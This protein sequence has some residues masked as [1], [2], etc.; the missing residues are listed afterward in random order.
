[1]TW[2]RIGHWIV[3]HAERVTTFGSV[4]FTTLLLISLY[5]LVPSS[6][7]EDLIRNLALAIGLVAGAFVG[8]FTLS[9]SISWVAGRAGKLAETII[10]NPFSLFGC[11]AATVLCFCL[12]LIILPT[13]T[14]QDPK[15]CVEDIW[16]FAVCLSMGFVL[17]GGSL[18]GSLAV[19]CILVGSWLGLKANSGIW[20]STGM[21][22]AQNGNSSLG[23]DGPP[24]PKGEG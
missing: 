18:I 24:S 23:P 17:L 3:K 12:F 21:P 13:L 11:C 15:I 1:M 8:L 6:A 14:D 9:F 19:P 16:Y 5:V 10:P 22:G 7:D 20:K 2:T 4:P